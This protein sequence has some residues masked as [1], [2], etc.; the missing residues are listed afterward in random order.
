[1]ESRL[2][3]PPVSGHIVADSPAVRAGS[4]ARAV[5]HAGGVDTE[6][7][8]AGHG[9]PMVLLAPRLDVPEVQVIVARLAQHFLVIAAG[10]PRDLPSQ[11]PARVTAASDTVGRWLEEFMEGLGYSHA[12][13]LLHSSLPEQVRSDIAVHSRT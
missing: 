2:D 1:M 3:R 13:V 10:L 8:R 5:V 11:H 9:E 7:L 12:H 4:P 6:Y